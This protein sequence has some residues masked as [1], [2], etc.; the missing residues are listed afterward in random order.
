MTILIT[1]ATGQVGG[2]TARALL[3]QGAPVRALVRNLAFAQRL[4]GAEIVQGSF[5]DGASLDRALTGV[6]ALL[7]VCAD[8]PDAVPHY[9]GVLERAWAAGVRHIVKLS[10]IGA[11]AYSPV[12]LMA[13]HHAL[14]ERLRAGPSGW[15]LLQPHLYLQNL[16]RAA[17]AIRKTGR[18]SAPMAHDAVPLVDA[19]DIGAAAAVVLTNPAAH[20]GK[21]YRLTGPQTI[22]YDQVAAAL[23]ALLGRP[24]EYEAVDPHDWEARLRVRDVPGWR[25]F[26]LAHILYAYEPPDNAVSADFEQLTGRPPTALATFLQDY[27]DDFMGA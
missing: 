23:S 3:A 7:L 12:H 13:D 4:E 19:R 6:D 2:A 21:T 17:P 14:D 15:T 9:V 26:D 20:Q 25:A 16:L 22:S 11:S 1:G 8:H 5:E 10:A 24:V 18:L 27:R